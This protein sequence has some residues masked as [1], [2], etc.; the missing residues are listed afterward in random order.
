MKKISFTKLAS[1]LFLLV[2]ALDANH[3]ALADR[4]DLT[5]LQPAE[6]VE[7]IK[8]KQQGKTDD[9]IRD[10]LQQRKEKVQKEQTE[11]LRNK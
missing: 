9:Q 6:R 11:P 1:A 10:I 7:A 3:P 2:L 4:I 8:L 5:K